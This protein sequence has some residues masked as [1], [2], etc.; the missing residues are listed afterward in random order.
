[1]AARLGRSWQYGHV[2]LWTELQGGA[3]DRSLKLDEPRV[4]WPFVGRPFKRA[5]PAQQYAGRRHARGGDGVTAD[6]SDGHSRD[7]F[8]IHGRAT[9]RMTAAASSS[10]AD[11]PRTIGSASVL[12]I[13]SAAPP[14]CS[15]RTSQHA[16]MA[17]ILA[18]CLE[19][20]GFWQSL[21]PRCASV[22]RKLCA[23]STGAPRPRT[24]P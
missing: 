10:T 14:S 18:P 1:M 15:C 22:R 8:P 5:G 2:Q 17:E 9:S 12:M 19:L 7:R 4:V 23:E 24:R 13:A 21:S 3:A 11:E 16:L 6:A 20:P